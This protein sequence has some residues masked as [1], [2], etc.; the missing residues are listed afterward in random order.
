MADTLP[1]SETAN[2]GDSQTTVPTPATPSV[3]AVDPAEVERL[4]KE[5]EQKELRIRQ[6]ENEARKKAEEEEAARQRQLEEQNEW[7][8]VAEQNKAKLEAYEKEREEAEARQE[9]TN[10]AN[11][12]LSTFSSEVQEEAKALGINLLSADD[13]SKEAFKAK[14]DRLSER[15][16]ANATPSANN[17]TVRVQSD[18][19]LLRRVRSGDRAAREQAIGNLQA[20]KTMRELSGYQN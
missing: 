14:L 2:P 15:V 3:N 8:Q 5:A 4:R 19:D 9:L 7:K 1:A 18:D 16:S 17:P 12:I 20:V 10:A 11:Q 13:G 6:L